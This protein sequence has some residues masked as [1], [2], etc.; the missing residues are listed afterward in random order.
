MNQ[1]AVLTEKEKEGLSEE[2][3]D[4]LEKCLVKDPTK[5]ITCE[6]AWI[7]PWIKTLNIKSILKKHGLEL[8]QLSMLKI[9][10]RIA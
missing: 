3:L 5:R 4:F 2:G 6:E 10:N 9:E 1:E 7:H 8:K